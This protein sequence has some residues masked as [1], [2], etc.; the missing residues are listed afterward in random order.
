MT[1]LFG[2]LSYFDVPWWVVIVLLFALMCIG[3]LVPIGIIFLVMFVA[4]KNRE[5]RRERGEED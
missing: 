2:F 3:I 5:E 4:R 1:P